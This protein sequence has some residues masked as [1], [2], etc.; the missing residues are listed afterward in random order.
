MRSEAGEGRPVRAVQPRT[1]LSSQVTP[2]FEPLVRQNYVLLTA[3]RR[4]G[5][6]VGT[7]VNIAVDG[8]RAFVRT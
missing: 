2:A 6:P 5:T 1:S 7:P 4:D 8:D 3:D